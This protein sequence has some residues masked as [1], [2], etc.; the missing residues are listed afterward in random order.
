MVNL[1][2]RGKTYASVISALFLAAMSLA[3]ETVTIQDGGYVWTA[4]D[5][6]GSE[7]ALGSGT[8]PCV[9]P[10]PS[11]TLTIPKTL[12]GYTV[13]ELSD[14]AFKGCK[15]LSAIRIPETVDYIGENVFDDCTALGEI[16]VR[17]G[18]EEYFS[19]NGVLYQGCP[20]D[21]C[22]LVRVPEGLTVSCFDGL[23]KPRV[24]EIYEG[25][26]KNCAG[27]ASVAVNEQNAEYVIYGDLSGC[28]SLSQFVWKGPESR[29][30]LIS[31]GVLYYGWSDRY[32]SNWTLAKCPPNKTT[33][34]VPTGV[35][36]IW[37]TA[38]GGTN[39]ETIEF[40]G[41]YAVPYGLE[42]LLSGEFDDYGYGAS[43][44][45]TVKYHYNVYA[46]DD[47]YYSDE[48]EWRDWIEYF[49]E[50]YPEKNISFVGIDEGF[51]EARWWY[52]LECG[53]GAYIYGYWL[54]GV[55][56]PTG[57]FEFPSEIE[58]MPVRSVEIYD[59]RGA[60]GE[61][62]SMAFPYT[63]EEMRFEGEY[64]KLTELTF[65][66]GVPYGLDDFL[67]E[68]ASNVTKI[69]YSANPRFEDGWLDFIEMAMAEFP[70][71]VFEKGTVPAAPQ[72]NVDYGELGGYNGD[73]PCVWPAPVGELK[74]PFLWAGV[75][76]ECIAW[77]A[78][79]GFDKMTSLKIPSSICNVDYEMFEKCTALATIDVY[80]PT[81]DEYYE[82]AYVYYYDCYYV[83]YECPYYEVS[84][85]CIMSY[86]GVVGYWDPYCF[87]MMVIPPAHKAEIVLPWYFEDNWDCWYGNWNDENPFPYEVV[88]TTPSTPECK[89]DFDQGYGANLYLA[90]NGT[91]TDFAIP[92]LVGNGNY[93][94]RGICADAFKALSGVKSITFPYTVEYI[95]VPNEQYVTV[96]N[97][98]EGRY[99][100]VETNRLE[101]VTKLVFAGAL[102]DDMEGLLFAMPNVAEVVYS[103]N[104]RFAEGWDDFIRNCAA[105]F[106]GVSFVRGAEPKEPQWWIDY[107]CL[108]AGEDFPCVWPAP[109]GAVEIPSVWAGDTIYAIDDFAFLGMSG[110]TSLKLPESLESV[111]YD[112]FAGCTG[113]EKFEMDEPSC[114]DS[115]YGYYY[116][117]YDD[118]SEVYDYYYDGYRVV[119]GVL[120][121]EM[122]TSD[123][124]YYG[125]YPPA[126]TDE[127]FNLIGDLCYYGGV[128]FGSNP[129]LKTV[130]IPYWYLCDSYISLKWFA[131]CK[132]FQEI[133]VVYPESWED[134]GLEGD[135]LVRDGAVY[136]GTCLLKVLKKANAIT[137][138]KWVED[139]D[140]EAFEGSGI[141]TVNF[142]GR[143]V[144][145]IEDVLEEYPNMKLVIPANPMYRAEWM[146]TGLSFTVAPE[147]EA[148]EWNYYVEWWDDCGPCAILCGEGEYPCMYPV[149]A[150]KVE[151]P[152]TIDGFKVVGME[153]GFTGCENVTE[154]VFPKTMRWVWDDY[155]CNNC[156]KLNAV[157]MPCSMEGFYPS[158][159][160]R[161][162][163]TMTPGDPGVWEYG[164]GAG[165]FF[166]WSDYAW[167]EES[168]AIVSVKYEAGVGGAEGFAFNGC[169]N[170]TKVEIPASF[171]YIGE[172]QF[173]NCSNLTE[174]VLGGDAP[175]LGYE[176]FAGCPK[177]VMYIRG[178]S[179]GWDGYAGSTEIPEFWENGE[180]RYP[181]AYQ[182]AHYTLVYDGDEWRTGEVIV[183]YDLVPFGGDDCLPK[184]KG[185]TVNR[186]FADP[187]C[188]V[189][190]DL[191]AKV[192]S[193]DAFTL[194]ASKTPNRYH[195][196]FIANGGEGTMAD[197]IL[198]YDKIEALTGITYERTYF[199]FLGWS[200][201]ADG[202][203]EYFDN[204]LVE[205]LASENGAVVVLYAMW[206]RSTLNSLDIDGRK[207][208]ESG[209]FAEGGVN[210][211]EGEATPYEAA[212][213]VYDGY[214]YDNDGKVVGTVQFKIAKGK[215]DKKTQAFS[216]KVAA[217]V[218]FA[219]G[220]KKLSF[221]NGVADETGVISVMTSG[222]WK[223]V[224]LVGMNSLAGFL[225]S[226]GIE[227]RIDGARN[228]FSA[229][230]AVDKDVAA[231][232]LKRWQGVYNLVWGL[233]RLTL[234]VG[235]KGKVKITGVIDGVKVS[236]NSQMLIGEAA[237]SVP[238]VVSK[239]VNFSCNVWFAEE[240]GVTVTGFD[241]DY[242]I[243]SAGT[244][245]GGAVV[246]FR[247][248]ELAD[249]LA[250]QL[251]G[252]RFLNGIDLADYLPQG[253]GV[254]ADGAK[255]AVAK[256]GKVALNKAK[257]G[258]DEAKVGGNPSGIKL[259]CKAK[260][261]SFKG[262]FK[263]YTNVNGSLK[264]T[265]VSV[266][267]VLVNGVGYG[268]MTVKKVGVW[269]M[270]IK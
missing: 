192:E 215:V 77:E 270:T 263:A 206:E 210:V 68:C 160:L 204:E 50:S 103:A 203:V 194:Y 6:G 116:S 85:D 91:E 109:M 226:G 143:P 61:V 264:S 31:D 218:Q 76:F 214:A 200:L 172:N 84:W 254:A 106:P 51:G 250:K 176:V 202:D 60:F 158:D 46:P 108:C 167:F 88:Y 163:L 123:G 57:N 247:A 151:I 43:K 86:D 13:R 168:K 94:V 128:Y 40:K 125:F 262:S 27:I 259:T 28:S 246:D 252:D 111:G 79:A 146:D 75:P 188:S 74:V 161:I 140:Y 212:A 237:C 235:S 17:D 230:G 171:F 162:A 132:N 7:I 269:P 257:D 10:L 122:E 243:G 124:E 213:A 25:A 52:E 36:D 48:S 137:I 170:L 178:D 164:E 173:S 100:E 93:P 155:L 227:Y 228:L 217:T 144:W 131:G 239:K 71:I 267:G 145:G 97:E 113:L 255:W 191:K 186:W 20:L 121:G 92:A 72:W 54:N 180:Y 82:K 153:D 134:D 114:D 101:S 47:F 136:D 154:V 195:V 149:A 253:I 184:T 2:L 118:Y 11:G 1:V 89:Y 157:T 96:Y 62:T 240:D 260:D 222:D 187:E 44:V 33:V 152:E 190:V 261:G 35:S 175:A 15:S 95:D 9:S 224:S 107:G 141:T 256:A 37:E 220:A 12:N 5:L 196:R 193:R 223:I 66:G 244:L 189:P 251:G 8:N 56:K 70:Q 182:K 14:C 159:E 112:A 16:V 120:Y 78:F 32:A 99:D 63:V 34:V 142:Q 105:N 249:A 59:D 156:K 169:P 19:Y 268:T 45:N 126:K 265:S 102:P 248:G 148:T 24:C 18:N 216:A 205:N 150:G 65:W 236:V 110:I 245:V 29:E 233:N 198:T 83:E 199:E 174:V 26:F 185:Y 238:V 64:G 129:Y 87:D 231:R 135:Y 183:G 38:F 211:A 42:D 197:Q 115:D 138:P 219:N 258:I 208:A 234:S 58:N 104:P 53:D 127:N 81:E 117:D 22:S 90:C 119:E 133:I 73:F 30:Y 266:D 209:A 241:A 147:P 139:I 181:L 41:A 207:I 232:T 55:D 80:T 98:Q 69:V 225:R 242:C 49:Q 21:E 23:L 177:V 130:T 201:T 4:V 166:H 229:K 39:V 67:Y 179:T 221:K 3:A 165:S